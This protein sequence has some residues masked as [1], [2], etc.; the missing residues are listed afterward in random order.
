MIDAKEA[1]RVCDKACIPPSKLEFSDLIKNISDKIEL[2]ASAGCDKIELSFTSVG[3]WRSDIKLV[4]LEEFLKE[5]GYGV[6]VIPDGPY[7]DAKLI[8]SW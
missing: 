8:I 1:R 6:R 7:S 2:V 3:I 4:D 5:N